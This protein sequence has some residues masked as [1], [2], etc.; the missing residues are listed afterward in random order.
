MPS[1]LLWFNLVV[2]S[3]LVVATLLVWVRGSR[4]GQRSSRWSSVMFLA[5]CL[6]AY[7]SAGVT[8]AGPPIAG[9]LYALV[10]VGSV[11]A[12]GSALM[13]ALALDREQRLSR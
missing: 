11:V 10:V 1:A 9:L 12:M 3:V 8:L 6:C 4:R 7:A 5:L 13:S 2:G